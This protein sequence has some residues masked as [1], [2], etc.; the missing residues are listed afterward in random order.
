M[1]EAEAE[2]V[3]E[4]MA[5]FLA[6][7]IAGDWRPGVVAHLLAARR[8]AGPLLALDLGDPAEPAPVYSP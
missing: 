2:R 6:L 1:T 4:A 8:I 5:V 3:M 7:P